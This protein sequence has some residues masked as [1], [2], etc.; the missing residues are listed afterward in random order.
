LRLVSFSFILEISFPLLRVIFGKKFEYTINNKR[1]FGDKICFS[2]SLTSSCPDSS[3]GK[4]LQNAFQNKQSI[5]IFY[6]PLTPQ[7]A[8]IKNGLTTDM[9][10]SL[11][12][13]IFFM[14]MGLFYI[15]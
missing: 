15:F 7:N 6:N 5:E 10:V 2:N 4:Y 12:G 3:L 11:L 13:L 8:T 14:S 9:K 1:Y